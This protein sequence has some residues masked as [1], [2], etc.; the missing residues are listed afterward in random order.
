VGANAPAST[1]PGGLRGLRANRAFA[2]AYR[3]VAFVLTL[4]GLLDTTGVLRGHFNGEMLLFYTTE[5]NLFVLIMFGI[6][7]GRTIA[8]IRRE[9]VRG[10]ASY[11]ERLS[12]IAALAIAVTMLVFWL[13]LAPTFDDSH[14]LFSYVNLQIHLIAPLLMLFEYLFFAMPGK[15]KGRV[16]WLFALIP[17]WYF[18]QATIIGFAGYTYTALG[19]ENQHFPY[20]FLDYY[21]LGAWVFAYGVAILVF[22]VGL[23]YV[24]LLCDRQRAR[25]RTR[26]GAS[27]RLG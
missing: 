24:L 11:H 22:F 16:P 19:Q 4:I 3:V 26:R 27:H 17:L 1:T 7:A 20:F 23:A 5:T 2:L 13:L 9:G 15:L 25:W 10:P 6:L 8:S 21:T 12:A 18:I 14:F